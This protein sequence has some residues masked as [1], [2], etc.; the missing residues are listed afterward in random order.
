MNK[1][2]EQ[3]LSNEEIENELDVLYERIDYL[4]SIRSSEKTL[5]LVDKVTICIAV[6]MLL[7]VL[8]RIL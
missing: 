8:I 5:D 3:T 4:E 2:Q 6:T 1:E 7:A